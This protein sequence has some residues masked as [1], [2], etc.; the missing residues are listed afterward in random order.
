RTLPSGLTWRE[1][2]PV[3]HAIVLVVNAFK[4][5][6]VECPS[7]SLADLERLARAPEFDED[8]FLARVGE[9]RARAMTW[10]VGDWLAT[11]PGS[12]TWA[13]IRERVA[14]PRPRSARA[15]ARAIAAHPHALGTRLLARAGSDSPLDAARA[16]GAAVAGTALAWIRKR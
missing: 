6:I 2:Q 8:L 10:I 15:Y 3:D 5:K 11:N 4:D 7:Y 13:R 14:S 12:A 1:P 9:A 16:L